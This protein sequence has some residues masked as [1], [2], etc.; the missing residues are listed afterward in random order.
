ML[1]KV[2]VND[3]PGI[4]KMNCSQ[5]DKFYIGQTEHIFKQRY[6]EHMK[7]W[8]FTIEYT[9][10]SHLIEINYTYTKTT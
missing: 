3:L 4:Y 6:N 9:F 7:A 10:A 1:L 8:H 2:E 5:C